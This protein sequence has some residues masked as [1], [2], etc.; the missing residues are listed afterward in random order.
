MIEQFPIRGFLPVSARWIHAVTFSVWLGGLIAIG[1]LVAPTAFGVVRINPAFAGDP[2]LQAQVAGGIVGGSLRRFNVLCYACGVL[3]IAANIALWPRLSRTGRACAGLAFLVV[4]ILL[5]AALY[6]GFGLFPAM[7]AAQA[8]DNKPLFD[9]LHRR[10]ERIST[11]IQ[12]PLLLVLALLAAIRDS[13]GIGLRK[14][15]TG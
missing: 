15:S 7:D 12:L 11:E 4:L 14:T 3:L 10:Y 5:A 8:Q 9:A 13:S 6:Q 1:A 2:V